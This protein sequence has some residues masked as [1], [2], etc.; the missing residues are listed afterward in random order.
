MS[1]EKWTPYDE[2]GWRSQYIVPGGSMTFTIEEYH[3]NL[4]ATV[5][6]KDAAEFK[7]H[8]EI[9]GGYCLVC[10]QLT[11]EP[12]VHREEAGDERW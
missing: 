5:V 10:H 1:D 11:D 3:G 2:F 4:I 7:R 9:H 8:I 12:H 6:F